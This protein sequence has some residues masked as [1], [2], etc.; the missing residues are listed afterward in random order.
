MLHIIFLINMRFDGY[1]G[2]QFSLE[3]RRYLRWHAHLVQDLSAAALDR[4]T[5]LDILA[6]QKPYLYPRDAT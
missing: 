6:L 3:H 5:C 1:V 4:R 2:D